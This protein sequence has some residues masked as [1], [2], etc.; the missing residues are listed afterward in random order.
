MD[1]GSEIRT[2]ASFV[3]EDVPQIKE[4]LGKIGS[5]VISDAHDTLKN[6]L[7]KLCEKS[8]MNEQKLTKL[9]QELENVFHMILY[10][11][12]LCDKDVI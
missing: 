9:K 12:C 3:E 7:I 11:I 1:K 6:E 2:L 5:C 4:K 10:L 8:N